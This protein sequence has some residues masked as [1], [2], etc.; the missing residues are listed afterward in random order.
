MDY[1]LEELEKCKN[2]IVYFIEKYCFVLNDAQKS[3]LKMIDQ[4]KFLVK[5]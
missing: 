1:D 3:F 5:L 4:N 2:D